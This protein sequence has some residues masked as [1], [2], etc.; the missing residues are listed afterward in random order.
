MRGASRVFADDALA[1]RVALIT[2]GGTHLGKAAAAELARCGAEVVIVGRREEIL[3]GAAEEIGRRCHVA[4][5]DIREA[6]QVDRVVA[7]VLERHGHIDFLLNNAGGQYFVPAES[8]TQKGW[9]AVQ[10][11]NV[12]G[13][14]TMSRAV[15]ARAMRPSRCNGTVRAALRHSSAGYLRSDSV[16]KR[17]IATAA[18]PTPSGAHSAASSRVKPST[19]ARAVPV[20]AMAGMP[21]CGETVTLTIMPRP[22]GHMA[23]AC[24]ARD[25]VSVPPTL[26]RCTARQPF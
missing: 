1:G 4:V 12:G 10:R 7:A 23:P 5:A 21:W 2:G 8:I 24:T 18:T 22:A 13:T 11:L 19:A 17:P 3:R 16:S 15:H 20:W 9:R 14:L 25:I 6:A 26:R